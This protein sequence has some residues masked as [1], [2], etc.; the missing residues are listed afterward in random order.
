MWKTNDP[1]FGT[2]TG[3]KDIQNFVDNVLPKKG[4]IHNMVDEGMK[5]QV[6]GKTFEFKITKGPQGLIGSIERL[7]Q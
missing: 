3:R 4:P 1:K 5:V 6:F 7:V 2:L